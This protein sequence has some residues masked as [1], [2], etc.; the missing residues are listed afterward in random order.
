[1]LDRNI[2]VLDIDHQQWRRLYDLIWGPYRGRQR[3]YVLHDGGRVRKVYH[4]L[5]GSLPASGVSVSD[6]RSCGKELAEKYDADETVIIERGKLRRLYA[7]W[8]NSFKQDEDFDEYLSW[9]FNMI[10]EAQDGAVYI[11][12]RVPNLRGITYE[13]LR[14][15]LTRLPDGRTAVLSIFH[16]REVWASLI[17]GKAGGRVNL[18]T[19]TD[20]LVSDGLVI[21]E[22]KKNYKDILRL[23]KAKFGWP[24]LGVF[25]TREEFERIWRAEDQAAAVRQ[26]FLRGN[27][28]LD[29]VPLEINLAM[30]LSAPAFLFI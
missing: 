7:M 4:S 17:V 1:M 20:A 29:P 16:G 23:V 11:Y 8:E 19:T 3:I 26:S 10:G 30:A 18:V 15:I 28:I 13:G 5:L 22:W 14:N 27:L 24:Y 9:F 2:M 6:P 21:T 25:T 12:T